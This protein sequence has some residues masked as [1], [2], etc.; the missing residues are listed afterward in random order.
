ME[1]VALPSPT[2]GS[3]KVG[4]DV[5][6]EASAIAAIEAGHVSLMSGNVHGDELVAGNSQ[7][8]LYTSKMGPTPQLPDSVSIKNNVRLFFEPLG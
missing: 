5:N 8:L 1:K 6:V 2:V 7:S 4:N 3:T